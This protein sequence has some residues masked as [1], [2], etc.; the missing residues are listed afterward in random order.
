[1]KMKG[2][3][4]LVILLLIFG[5]YAVFDH[6]Q[7]KS[8][9]EKKIQDSRIMTVNFEQVNEVLIEKDER[10]T[11]LKRDV[12][13]WRMEVP[14]KDSA[15]NEAVEDLVKQAFTETIIEVVKEGEGID[16]KLYGLDKPLGTITFKT[17]DGQQNHY[18]I[19]SVTNFEDNAFVRRD[20]E[21][22]VL[23]VNSIWQA[24]TGKAEV[25]FRDRRFLRHKIAAVDEIKL[26]NS[27]GLVHLERQEGVWQILGKPDFKVDQNKVRSTLTTIADAKAAEIL[28]DPKKGPATKELFTLNLVLDGK[29]WSG[30]V[31]QATDKKIFA[32][33]SEPDF[34]MKLEPGAVDSLIEMTAEQFKEQ[35]PEKPQ[36]ETEKLEKKEN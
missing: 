14:L 12:D 20:G 3:T 17:S 13:G 16:W 30:K 27:K 26:K 28:S 21:N 22:R 1:M 23:L 24:R 5:G 18:E 15:D 36:F 35:P 6:Y 10:V 33:V 32:K 8:Q 29:A 4:T 7:G 25:A 31:G 34:L 9:E 11:H 19:S 2:R